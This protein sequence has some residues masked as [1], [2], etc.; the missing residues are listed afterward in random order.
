[1][2]RLWK[3]EGYDIVEGVKSS[4]GRENIFKKMSAMLFYW[5]MYK[6]SG[7]RLSNAS[8][9]KLMDTKAVKALNRLGERDTFMRGMSAWIG[10]RRISIPFTVAERTSGNSRWSFLKLFKLA[11]NAITSFS[12]LPLHIV[13]IMGI[14][15]LIG[16]V[17][18]GIQTLY[19]KIT[20]SALD[21]F[22][23]MILLQLIIGST[24]M[25]SL[26]IIGSYIARIFNEVKM[27][28]RYLISE[29]EG[30]RQ[31]GSTIVKGKETSSDTK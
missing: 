11:V 4:R 21:G 22:T 26:G 1:M 3:D 27:R 12:S 17:I 13:T 6:F 28:P 25:L 8:D 20:G 30:P 24:L 18:L 15:F 2:I 9:F 7:V 10:Y 19:R 5:M 23:T 14:L 29:M 16:S 31:D